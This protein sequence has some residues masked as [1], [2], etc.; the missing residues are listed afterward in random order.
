MFL[1]DDTTLRRRV[2]VKILHDALADDQVFL[3]RFRAEA[4]A[5]AALNNPHIMA[6]YDW[7]QDGVPFIVSEYLG[8]GSLRAI[9][10]RNERLSPSQALLIG[11]DTARGLDY[12]H[13]RGL[14]HR[15]IKP[16]NLLFD[17][18]S[19]L[20]IADFGLARAL[21]EAATTEPNGAMVGTA[22]Y[23]SP[24]QAKGQNVDQRA[25]IYAL[26][27]VLC[28][29]VTG[30]VPFVSD[31]TIT[32]LMARVD[33]PLEAP[34]ELGPLREIV[35]RGG[36]P[37]PD[38][39][40]NAEEFARSLM[41]A[42]Q[43]L[44]RPE[45]LPLVGAIAHEG[46]IASEREPT[47]HEPERTEGG[48]KANKSGKGSDDSRYSLDEPAVVDPGA[49]LGSQRRWPWIA[50]GL[51]LLAGLAGFIAYQVLFSG[52]PEHEIPQLRGAETDAAVAQLNDLGF[53]V[54]PRD[55]R[56]DEIDPGF[57]IGTEPEAGSKLE[58]G[59][60]V[61]VINSLGPTTVARPDDLIGQPVGAVRAELE[62]RELVPGTETEQF[63]EELEAGLVIG[64]DLPS[65]QVEVPKGTT[66]DMFVSK[67][68][69]PRT[70]PADLVGMTPE[71]AK[72]ALEELGLVVDMA[73]E[74]S[75]DVDQGLVAGTRPPAGEMIDFGGTVT[76]IVSDGP[77]PVTI[78]SSIIGVSF[79]E[80]EGTLQGLG[81]RVSLSAGT[82]DQVVC[83]SDPAPGQAL[84]RGSTVSLL[85]DCS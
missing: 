48:S 46:G 31:T 59:S 51:L 81:F 6:V 40:P 22:R 60:E 1:A 13:K 55:G 29:T 27:L 54:V 78:P 10:D 20:R 76:I 26:S 9:L 41:A 18:D 77:E 24:E 63:D 3:R 65:T 35:A 19:R 4:Q 17:E 53:V 21:A 57:V 43:Q 67:G 12:A 38:D 75:D 69:E 64:F 32:T 49:E 7:G 28:E 52:E 44:P 23:A 68:P 56:D 25:D 37:D 79:D 8:G 58:E 80:A 66:I 15:D 5:A 82:T 34:D 83:G 36:S 84:P 14:V 42:A 71:D 50:L 85:T 72:A 30:E 73:T 70:I 47:L 45:S 16:G 33:T 74:Y 11:L 39:R 62:A 2:A 61:V